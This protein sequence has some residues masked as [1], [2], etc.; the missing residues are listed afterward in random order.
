MGFPLKSDY[1]RTR[2]THSLEVSA[3][4]KKLGEHVYRKL[5]KAK[6]E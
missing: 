4:G 1:V 6:V 3:I 5:K 2:L